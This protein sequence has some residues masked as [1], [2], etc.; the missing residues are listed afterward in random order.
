[1][2][3]LGPSK[4]PMRKRLLKALDEKEKE[5]QKIAEK[6]LGQFDRKEWK[7]W[8]RKFPP[9]AAFFPVES[10]VFQRL[11]LA[12]LNEAVELYQRA[13]KSSNWNRLASPPSWVKRLPVHLGEFSSC[14]IRPQQQGAEAHAGHS[15]RG[16]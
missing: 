7:K 15:G 11:A 8:S 16:S 14:E 5:A 6:T 10:V 4:D 12:K 1:V 9:K 13:K 3:K 2:K